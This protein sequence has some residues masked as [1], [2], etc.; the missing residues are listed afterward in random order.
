MMLH[1]IAVGNV[2]AVPTCTAVTYGMNSWSFCT[3]ST[4]AGADGDAVR[5]PSSAYNETTASATGAPLASTRWKR[6][7]S[8]AADKMPAA[9]AR[10]IAVPRPVRID[11]KPCAPKAFSPH[12]RSSVLQALDQAIDRLQRA[13]FG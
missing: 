11:Q 1:G 5:A 9:S 3:T 8:S 4:E 12:D 10:Q 7:G 6:A 2:T 13:G